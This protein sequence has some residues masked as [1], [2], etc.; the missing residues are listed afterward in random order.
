MKQHREAFN[1]LVKFRHLAYGSRAK[2]IRSLA[3]RSLHRREAVLPLGITSMIVKDLLGDVT[4]GLP[5]I[6]RI[7]FEAYDKLVYSSFHTPFPTIKSN[8]M[9][10]FPIQRQQIL[11]KPYSHEHQEKAARLRQEM[12]C[13]HDVLQ[14]QL[15]C[16]IQLLQRDGRGAVYTPPAFEVDSEQSILPA[17][18]SSIRARIQKFSELNDEAVCLSDWNMKHV[19]SINDRHEAAILILTAVT[20]IF[21]PLSFV[22]SIFG[23][24]TADIRHTNKGQWVFWVSAILVT[25]AVSSLSLFTYRHF[26]PVLQALDHLWHLKGYGKQEGDDSS[27]LRFVDASYGQRGQRH[28]P[29]VFQNPAGNRPT[30]IRVHRKYMCPETLDTYELPWE[31]DCRDS[32]YLIIKRW[33]P[34]NDQDILFEHTRKLREGGRIEAAARRRRVR[35]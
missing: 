32:D 6:S 1:E 23:M 3:Q 26:R 15:G 18:E 30:Y 9:T 7:Y 19:E 2:L 35:R 16:V 25:I 4:D 21:L 17:C 33:I 12:G 10:D 22:S 31:W 24:N 8:I 27:S 13:I 20:V 34:E 11:S 5:D 29:N 28:E 14:D